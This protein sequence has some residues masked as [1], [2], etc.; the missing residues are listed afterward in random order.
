MSDIPHSSTPPPSPLR[1]AFL[2]GSDSSE[3]RAAIEGICSLA[4]IQPLGVLLDTGQTPF[5][6]RL[7]NLRRNVRAQGLG[8]LAKRFLGAARQLTERLAAHAAAPP[9]QVDQLLRRAFPLRAFDLDDLGRRFGFSVHQAGNLNH[10][11][12]ARILTELNA[13][14]GIVLGTRILKPCIFRVPALGCINLHKGHVPTYRGL[15]PGFWELFDGASMAGVTVH[16]VDSGLDTGDILV[17]RDIP[18]LNSDTPD[19]LLEKLHLEGNLALTQA[20]AALR[21][22]TAVRRQQVHT[23]RKARSKPSAAN[24]AQLRHRLPH[25]RSES[26]LH[27]TVKNVYALI[28]YYSGVYRLAR[29]LHS[30]SRSRAAII[31]HH[32][33]NDYANDPLTVDISTFAAHLVAL[34]ARYPRITTAELVRCVRENQPIPPTSISIHFDDCYQDILTNGAPLLAAAGVPATAF[35]NSGF[36]GTDRIFAH[37][38]DT[39]PFRFPNL[40][41]QDVQAWFRQGFEVGNHTVNHVDLGR[42][43]LPD[44]HPEIVNCDL[45]LSRTIEQRIPYVSFPF[46]RVDNIRPEVVDL[47]R[48]C[49]HDALFAAHGG[50]VNAHTDPFDIPR[51]G[52]NGDLNPLLLLLE[53]EGLAPNQLFRR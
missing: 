32:R 27:R 34:T 22:G 24:V 6:G 26:D 28:V 41:P 15:P 4:N 53:L 14:L 50:F 20:V 33:V 39:Y 36:I 30:F 49:G 51:L 31:L 16:F 10:P 12:A 7:R 38:A 19:T 37:D 11:E 17:S 25:W 9:A 18:I 52:A 1:V 2:V 47:I 23:D 44:V 42:H 35:I 45:V 43:P 3:I 21:D 48:Q 13:D 8:Y 5:R 46:G 40:S 29:F